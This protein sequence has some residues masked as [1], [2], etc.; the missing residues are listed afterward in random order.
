[1]L[2]YV[3]TQFRPRLAISDVLNQAKRTPE[4]IS[5]H[6]IVNNRCIKIESTSIVKISSQLSCQTSC[7]L[8][9]LNHRH[10]ETLHKRPVKI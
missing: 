10:S 4:S 2:L 7:S 1:M 8:S 6:S 9:L 5:K 3:L